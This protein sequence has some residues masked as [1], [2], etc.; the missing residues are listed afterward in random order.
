[1]DTARNRLAMIARKTGICGI[2]LP[3][4]GYADD[5]EFWTETLISN[6][7]TSTDPHHKLHTKEGSGEGK[8]NNKHDI[9][10]NG[11]QMD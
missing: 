4:Q 6:E 7:V 2:Q 10:D 3:S 8:D 11:H 9:T 5:Q 1:M